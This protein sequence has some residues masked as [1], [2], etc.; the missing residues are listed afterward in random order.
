MTYAIFRIVVAAAAVVI[1][2]ATS[3]AEDVKIP[4]K[5]AAVKGARLAKFVSKSAPGTF[6]IPAPGSADDPTIAGALLR[7]FDTDEPGAGEVSFLL[8][9][10]GWTGLGNPA[11]S[12]GYK[13]KGRNDAVDPD[14]KGACRTVLLKEKVI[15]A[16]CGGSAVTL[17]PPFSAAAG[18][19]LGILA[20]STAA[21][22]C[23]TFGGEEKRNDATIT[24]RKNASAP[25][26]CAGVPQDRRPCGDTAY[27][28]HG[29]CP[30][31]QA[32]H[33]DPVGEGSC[34]CL[35]VSAVPCQDTGGFPVPG[36]CGGA[37]P[38]GLSCATI[39]VTLEPLNISCACIP[40]DAVACAESSAP[41]CGGT[42]PSGLACHA[43]GVGNFSCVCT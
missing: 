42:C 22:Y 5:L 40:S 41:A 13:Y 31:G 30:E 24:K 23:A 19:R 35:T 21:R 32:C 38:D 34:I 16:V 3:R 6:P 4:G 28:C 14:P 9:Q 10:S 25:S 15:K 12:K 37:C 1:S 2:A 36:M 8:D 11:G 29:E 17:A 7:V 26:E 43:G 18:I 27:A 33:T 39:D 20:G